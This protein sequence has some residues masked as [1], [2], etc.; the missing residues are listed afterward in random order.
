MNTAMS[1]RRTRNRAAAITWLLAVQEAYELRMYRR[2]PAPL[3]DD[4]YIDDDEPVGY[5]VQLG[6]DSAPVYHAGYDSSSI[7]GTVPSDDAYIVDAEDWSFSCPRC[8][9]SLSDKEFE[10]CGNCADHKVLE[11]ESSYPPG[12][13]D[14]WRGHNHKALV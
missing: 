6:G 4:S 12:S 8:S 10:L 14:K 5:Y 13:Y 2:R 7:Q 1:T 9:I 11:A 3:V